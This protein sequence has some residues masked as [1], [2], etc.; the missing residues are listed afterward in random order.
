MEFKEFINFTEGAPPAGPAGEYP[1]NQLAIELGIRPKDWERT[2]MIAKGMH[3][4]GGGGDENSL[5][6]KLGVFGITKVD[7]SD[8]GEEVK[9]M[10]GDILPTDREFTKSGRLIPRSATNKRKQRNR[11]FDLKT[12]ANSIWGQGSPSGAGAGAPGGSPT[13]GLPG[14]GGMPM[15]PMGG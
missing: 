12:I 1:F 5:L 6:K 8:D 7:A 13:G 11:F 3:D 10:R 2:T 9:S 4:K 14:S 15:P